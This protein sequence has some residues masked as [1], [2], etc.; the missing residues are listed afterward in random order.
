MNLRNRVTL[1]LIFFRSS[2]L[3]CPRDWMAMLPIVLSPS[4]S[5][6]PSSPIISVQPT[7]IRI[8]QTQVQGQ[9]DLSN[10]IQTEVDQAF[11]Q[12]LTLLNLVLI[13]LLLLP[14]LTA[15]AA[16]VLL[17]KLITQTALAKQEI[18]SLK[19]DP[20]SQLE[21][22]IYEAKTLLYNLQQQ[23]AE[24]DQALEQLKTRSSLKLPQAI[25]ADSQQQS[26]LGRDYAKQG[27]K[28]FL[29]NR[30]EEAINAYDKALQLQPSLAEV[31]NNRGVV[32][33]KLQ[34]YHE[35]IASYE[36][37][38]Q[39]RSDYS[40]AWN[41][42]GV[43]L[44]KL[45]YYDAA[46][47]SYDRAIQLKENYLDAWNNRGFALTQLKQYEEAIT[48]YQKA[49]EINP[50]FYLIWYNKSRCY[51][52][53]EQAKLALDSLE[54]AIKLKPSITRNLAKKETDFAAIQNEDKFQQLING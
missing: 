19:S 38:I 42:R 25:P 14:T 31:W 50:D 54:K 28:F 51:A 32:L 5:F 41:N 37:A 34:R 22:I 11:K 13:V 4:L 39:L 53:Q 3:T 26:A 16:G 7:P 30:Y 21:P 18:E 2:R 36:Q 43:A 9:V 33:T 20:L 10:R 17:S 1:P 23:N 27:E 8:V 35:A 29:E 49:E 40:D 12:T 44:G 15:I 52:M 46:V 48:S 24:V 6:L 47:S 45:K